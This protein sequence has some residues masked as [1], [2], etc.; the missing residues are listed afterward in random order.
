[1]WIRWFNIHNGT[2]V[3]TQYFNNSD[4]IAAAKNYCLIHPECDWEGM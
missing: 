1:M 4:A 3:K 2:T